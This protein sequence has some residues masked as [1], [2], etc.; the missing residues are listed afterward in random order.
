MDT[1]STLLDID[2]HVGW[3]GRQA[4]QRLG[5]HSQAAVSDAYPIGLLPST[6][7]LFRWQPAELDTRQDTRLA[8]Q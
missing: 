5:P 4:A 6:K 8:H 1:D 7:S 2:A 3:R